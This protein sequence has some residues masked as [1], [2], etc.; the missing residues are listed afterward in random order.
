MVHV[1][2][3]LAAVTGNTLQVDGRTHGLDAVVVFLVTGA[4]GVSGM[5]GMEVFTDP[6]RR[7]PRHILVALATAVQRDLMDGA[8]HG[9]VTPEAPTL[10]PG[11]PFVGNGHPLAREPGVVG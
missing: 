5:R 6:R 7:G 3:V 4:A 10:D 2:S 9:V 1:H 11:E 8:G